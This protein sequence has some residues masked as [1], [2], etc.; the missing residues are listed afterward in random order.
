MTTNAANILAGSKAG[1]AA[2][3]SLAWLAPAGT[4]IPTDAKT[5]LTADYKDGGMC[6]PK[7]LSIKTNVSSTPVKAFGSLQPVLTL[8]TDQTQTI[9]VTFLES[10]L[11][12][13]EVYKGF[14][15][16]S[17]VADPAT[18]AIVVATKMPKTV[19]YVAAFDGFDQ[20][21]NPFRIVAPNVQN[22]NPGDLNIA[23]GQVID[24]AV[25]LTCYPDAAGV[26]LYEHYVL[27]AL[28]TAP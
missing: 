10:S 22:T 12:A 15:L 21:G 28:K 18:G 24:R 1:G 19:R 5:P 14:E 7:G 20:Y 6:D 8:Y 11:T 17:T 16:G 4:A 27:P 25:S 3:L 23:M 9:D 26:S 2:G 13:I